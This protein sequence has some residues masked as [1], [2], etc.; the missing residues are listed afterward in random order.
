[1]EGFHA[2]RDANISNSGGDVSPYM[3]QRG[4]DSLGMPY[5]PSE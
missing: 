4:L 1:M 2:G 3:L 5:L